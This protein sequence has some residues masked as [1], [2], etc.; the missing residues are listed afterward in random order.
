MKQIVCRFVPLYKTKQRTLPS[1][2]YIYAWD[3]FVRIGGV[4]GE[5]ERG[6]G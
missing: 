1:C 5:E 4:D 6:S 2:K 3:L